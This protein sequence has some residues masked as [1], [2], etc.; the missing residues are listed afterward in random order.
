MT[1]LSHKSEVIFRAS[2]VDLQSPYAY[3][4]KSILGH[5]MVT[6]VF[7]TAEYVLTVYLLRGT[8]GHQRTPE[9]P[10]WGAPRS[11]PGSRQKT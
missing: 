10:T 3:N 9:I 1:I 5:P 11:G 8:G 4:M 6:F 2:Y 7:T